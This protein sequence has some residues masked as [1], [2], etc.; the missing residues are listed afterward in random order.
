[1]SASVPRWYVAVMR[2]GR[3]PIASLANALYDS[4]ALGVGSGDPGL[5]IGLVRAVLE[6]GALGLVE[7]VADARLAPRESL[8]V[9]V[10]Q[11]EELFR[12]K[13]KDAVAFVKLLLAAIAQ[14]QYPI[15]VV[16]TMRSD[17]L[18]D[19]SQF[20][21]LPEAISESLFL[22]PRLT[23][24]QLQRA[25]EGPIR[26]AG[27]TIAPRLTNRLLNDLEDDADQL[28]VLQHALMRT[29]DAHAV[30]RGSA[31]LDI[32]DLEGIGALSQALSLHGDEV[33]AGLRT[34]RLRDV[35]EKVFKCLTDRGEDNRGVRRPTRFADVCAIVDAVPPEVG[36]VVEAFRAPGC[37]FLMPPPAVSVNDDTVL[38]ISHESLMRI[39]KRLQRWVEEEAQSAQIYRRLANAAQLY[40]E[41][42]AA[43]WRDPDLQ[44][45]A[46]WRDD[47]HP[48]EAWGER[49]AGG[50]QHAMTFLEASLSDRARTRSERA[51]RLRVSLAALALVALAL[52]GL[53][54]VAFSQWR[55]ADA[56]LRVER[57]ERLAD[58]S[59]QE[60]ARGATPALLAADAYATMKTPRT[61]GAMLEH[62][63]RLQM[64]RGAA[65][66]S[67]TGEAFA[68]RG[69]L[70]AAT[71]SSNGGSPE[72]VVFD[73]LNLAVV[74]HGPLD[75]RGVTKFCASPDAAWLAATDGHSIFLYDGIERGPPQ[76]TGSWD[77]GGVD[78][79]ACLARRRAVIVAGAASGLRV[80]DFG[81][82]DQRRLAAPPSER[83]AAIVA[84]PFGRFVA[85]SS[86]GS[87]ASH[88]DFYDLRF[89][90]N[91]P[92]SRTGCS[93]RCGKVAFSP[94]EQRAAWTDGET[95]RSLVTSSPTT[96]ESTPCRC[97][98][99]AV[100]YGAD[101][102]G[103]HVVSG[104]GVAPVYDVS[105]E[106]YV[107]HDGRGIAEHALDGAV[108]PALGLQKA[109]TW[110][111]SFASI[112]SALVLAG[113][114]G[115]H[116]YDLTR[117]RSQLTTGGDVSGVVRISDP[118]DGIHAVALNYRTGKARIYTV[119][120][121]VSVT[122]D[123]RVHSASATRGSFA[124]EP[125]I[126]YNPA[127]QTLTEASADGISR[128]A[129]SGREIA[130]TPW[131]EIAAAAT[132]PTWY[133]A[134]PY[135]LSSRGS[136]VGLAPPQIS[137]LLPG[138]VTSMV[139]LV[140][141]NGGLVARFASAPNVSIDQRYATG[142]LA[143]D[144]DTAFGVYRL[145]RVERQPGVDLPETR[146]AAI[147]PDAATIAYA[148]GT[149]PRTVTGVA[150][151]NVASNA[152]VGPAIPGP[153]TARSIENISFSDDARYLLVTYDMESARRA[154]VV[155]SIDPA[156]WE[157]ILC[158]WAGAQLERTQRTS[159][160]H[161]IQTTDAC[162]RY[163][164]EMAP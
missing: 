145:Q 29:W 23:R 134:V 115:L 47:N 14:T 124:D 19:V 76:L 152:R 154:L 22:V 18:G 27:G 81:T 155:Y 120:S 139:A 79:M 99:A 58:L 141:T 83:V 103:P 147:S 43:L 110:P 87:G 41:G 107:T 104:A 54:A 45:A 33:F 46:N 25:I 95:V 151:F 125:E 114:S 69:Q 153:R 119:R 159:A 68:R 38:D 118:G 149:D 32:E 116:V 39:W 60:S 37:S 50:F 75:V 51:S 31:A 63:M 26:V 3:T 92:V 106:T 16:M 111:G 34:D 132:L 66:G 102:S 133:P 89:P 135:L 78:A 127:E 4:G 108:A 143:S 1:M 94:D 121:T 96:V 101:G 28:P 117:Y 48:T 97:V 162:T 123:F 55:I 157:R 140:S 91:P 112:G 7:V 65:I 72:L 20:R 57:A 93:R 73:A 90:G 59:V 49:I 158:L 160:E 129:A 105:T 86:F 2:P 150:L 163:A 136:Y 100:V 15:Y 67:V 8:L 148:T 21:A 80:L 77:A 82:A 36:E 156:D 122:G 113:T 84:S 13:A 130:R 61:A 128:Y 30:S 56:S 62:L 17:F 6:R 24:L 12:F 64:L 52:A 5:R 138:A 42:K 98:G 142:V 137:E 161:G 146:M 144:P 9:V 126:G 131:S 53:S 44:I 71:T 10:D 109:P 40:F 74:A 11:F 70:L 164:A 85:V 88:V 35:A